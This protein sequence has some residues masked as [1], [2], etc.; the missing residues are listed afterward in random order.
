EFRDLDVLLLEDGLAALVADAGGP[1]LPF[2]LVVGV[3]AGSG[4]A[5]G[6]VEAAG[7][8]CAVFLGSVEARAVRAGVAADRYDGGGSGCG[9]RGGGRRPCGGGPCSA[10]RT[11]L[12]RSI[13][14][15]PGDTLCRVLHDR[16]CIASDSSHTCAPRPRPDARQAGRRL[17]SRAAWG[18]AARRR[19][20]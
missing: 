14:L 3:D 10:F 1:R 2:D 6:E 11:R 20:S 12:H 16:D 13:V 7:G 17:R 9:S 15:Q 4:P 18:W 19:R 8:G 5:P